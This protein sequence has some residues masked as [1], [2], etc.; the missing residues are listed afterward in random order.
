[1]RALQRLFLPRHSYAVII[2]GIIV[3]YVKFLYGVHKLDYCAHFAHY[4]FFTLIGIIE[5]AQITQMVNGLYIHYAV[6]PFLR[7]FFCRLWQNL[8]THYSYTL[9]IIQHCES[10]CKRWRVK[11]CVKVRFRCVGGLRYAVILHSTAISALVAA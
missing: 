4:L 8:L 5:L 2:L 6:I 3:N 7:G 11:N 9:T 1:M 10:I